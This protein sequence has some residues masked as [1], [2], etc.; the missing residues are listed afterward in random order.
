MEV[1]AIYRP[2]AAPRMNMR[3][4]KNILFVI[5]FNDLMR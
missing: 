1:A 3:N 5:H 2:V 4:T